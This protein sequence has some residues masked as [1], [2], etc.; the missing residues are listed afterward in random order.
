MNSVF[1]IL[2]SKNI[3]TSC[4]MVTL[5]ERF[6]DEKFEG[7]LEY[8]KELTPTKIEE[9]K[10][11]K[12]IGNLK[13]DVKEEDSYTKMCNLDID[14]SEISIA[15]GIFRTLLSSVDQNPLNE[16]IKNS[17]KKINI[18]CYSYGGVPDHE[19]FSLSRGKEI[20]PNLNHLVLDDTLDRVLITHDVLFT[21]IIQN[22]VSFNKNNQ[23]TIVKKKIR[24]KLNEPMIM[25]NVN[26]FYNNSKDNQITAFHV[27]QFSYYGEFK[28]SL[29][30]SNGKYTTFEKSK[31]CNFDGISNLN[32]IDLSG[33]QDYISIN[34]L[35]NEDS[36]V[37]E[38]DNFKI[39][40]SL[41]AALVVKPKK[42]TTL[43]L[44]MN[45]K[46]D[47][48]VRN[49]AIK[50][51]SGISSITNLNLQSSLTG[52][53]VDDLI[54]L[55]SL[56]LTNISLRFRH[57]ELIK[58]NKKARATLVNALK[59]VKSLR[60]LTIS[61][62]DLKRKITTRSLTEDNKRNLPTI[63]SNLIGRALKAFPETDFMDQITIT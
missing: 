55:S 12:S 24:M 43:N 20:F 47:D 31:E 14:I 11:F 60:S 2:K 22:G 3:D 40:P 37:V 18:Y 10:Y 13:F 4:I 32:E 35:E 61:I 21:S 58:I 57:S 7:A 39:I 38:G 29:V 30:S 26:I 49:K 52:D 41:N 48:K 19:L 62:I 42:C 50:I 59:E 23:E 51:I 34:P 54:T 9:A 53:L 44:E 63:L 56:N 33:Y 28:A 25:E 16:T 36:I 1:N 8:T 27:D 45:S 17:V 5:P 15:P 46:L 6:E